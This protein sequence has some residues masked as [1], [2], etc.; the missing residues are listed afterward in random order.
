MDQHLSPINL[1]EL[2][3]ALQDNRRLVLDKMEDLDHKFD[4]I[5]AQLDAIRKENRESNDALRRELQAYFVAKAEF[6]PHQQYVLTKFAEY[7]RIV[8]ESRQQTPE[9][10]RYQED[11]KNI[12]KQLEEDEKRKDGTWSRGISV[13]SILIALSGWVVMLLQHFSFHP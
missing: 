5:P 3:N 6:L 11:I 2:V 7:D 13:V 10:V 9:W 8:N 12:K 4:G 1:S